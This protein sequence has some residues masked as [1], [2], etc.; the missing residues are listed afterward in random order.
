M[1]DPLSTADPSGD[2]A[3]AKKVLA[4][5]PSIGESGSPLGPALDD[6]EVIDL[7]RRTLGTIDVMMIGDLTDPMGFLVSAD[8]DLQGFANDQ[9]QIMWSLSG[10]G[11]TGE[12]TSDQVVQYVTPTADVDHGNVEIWVPDLAAPGDYKVSVSIWRVSDGSRLDVD[13][14]L[15]IANP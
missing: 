12:W 2:A 1:V 15:Q 13:D 5:V 7:L 10:P 6:Q 8:Y 9:L 4:A 3:C 14:S 11:V